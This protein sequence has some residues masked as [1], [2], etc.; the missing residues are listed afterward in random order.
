VIL[1]RWGTRAEFVSNKATALPAL[2]H[3]IREWIETDGPRAV[4]ESTG[5]SDG[6]FLDALARDV[7]CFVVRF[8]VSE[9]EAERRLASRARGRH[10]TDDLAGN[11]RVRRELEAHVLP[12]RPVDLV[13][14]GDHT[15]A[16]SAAAQ[17]AS[18]ARNRPGEAREL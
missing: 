3:D 2:Q 5:L 17:I 15:T 16:A 4:I 6:T 7:P 9:A 1:E 11:R 14:D 18:A 10:L 13:I 8:D 12:H